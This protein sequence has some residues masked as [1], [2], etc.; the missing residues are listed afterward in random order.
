MYPVPKARSGE[1]TGRG[2]GGSVGS[3]VQLGPNAQALILDLRY[4][5]R[6]S[7]GCIV[8]VL[9]SWFGL[10]IHQGRNHSAGRPGA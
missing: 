7:L 9:G 4:V 3:Q 1:A 6:M 10:Q 5:G 2:A 8:N